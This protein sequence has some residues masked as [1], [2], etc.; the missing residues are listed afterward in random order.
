MVNISGSGPGYAHTII[1]TPYMHSL[2]YHVPVM[3]RKHR[4]LKKFSGQGIYFLYFYFYLS[5]GKIITLILDNSTRVL[6]IKI[7]VFTIN[8]VKQTFH[9][10]TGV[11]KKND[12]LRRYFHRK[13]NRWDAAT[14]LL[15]VEKRQ[16]KLR[17]K[18]RPKRPYEKRDSTYWIEGGKQEAAKKVP[19]ISTSAPPAAPMPTAPMPTAMSESILKAKK[20]PDL[21]A[22]LEQRT[23]RKVN[24]KT[25]K[26]EIINALLSSDTLPR[27][28]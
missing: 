9:F 19:R 15:L 14:N 12:D 4:S 11:E 10:T 8:K 26:Q 22:L 16:E 27:S 21:I 13:I 23:G 20:V 2:V 28:E 24:K 3:L 5:F 6:L 7:I 18:E 17:E 1:I 25:R